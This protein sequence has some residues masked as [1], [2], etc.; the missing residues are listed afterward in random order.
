MFSLWIIYVVC[1]VL[2]VYI[3]YINKMFGINFILE[4][5][6]TSKEPLSTIENVSNEFCKEAVVLKKE[7]Y[8]N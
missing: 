4:I 6:L 5:R 8:T 3:V 1:F 2:P 7:K